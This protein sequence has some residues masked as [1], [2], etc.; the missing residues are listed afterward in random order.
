MFFCDSPSGF[1][2]LLNVTSF[3]VGRFYNWIVVGVDRSVSEVS[4]RPRLSVLLLLLCAAG[5]TLD[6]WRSQLFLYIHYCDGFL[7][8]DRA[9]LGVVWLVVGVMRAVAGVRILLPS[10]HIVRTVCLVGVG[11]HWGYGNISVSHFMM[12]EPH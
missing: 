10:L 5:E 8:A 3:C 9:W 7:R 11:L 2:E 1:C 4:A 6:A 12:K